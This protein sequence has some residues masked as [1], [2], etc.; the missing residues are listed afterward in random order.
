MPGLM[1]GIDASVAREAS[2]AWMAGTGDAVAKPRPGP[3]EPLLI[4][5]KTSWSG[6]KSPV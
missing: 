4:F 2:K 5:A 6:P 3:F 1:P